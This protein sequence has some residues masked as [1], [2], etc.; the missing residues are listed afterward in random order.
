MKSEKNSEET[1]SKNSLKSS[2]KATL[3]MSV[4]ET[5]DDSAMGV[6]EASG[7]RWERAQGGTAM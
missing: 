5:G 6:H 3:F 7:L 1:S 2:K 4:P